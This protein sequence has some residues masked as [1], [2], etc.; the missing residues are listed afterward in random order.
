MAAQ[1]VNDKIAKVEKK[2][3]SPNP[4]K[5]TPSSFMPPIQGQKMN[6]PIINNFDAPKARIHPPQSAKPTTNAGKEPPQS[7]R[8]I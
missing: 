6:V 3:N 1:G 4:A 7:A 8:V 5:E 2:M